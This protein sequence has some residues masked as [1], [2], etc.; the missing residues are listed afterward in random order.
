MNNL[1]D[2]LGFIPV[3]EGLVS[4]ESIEKDI[5]KIIIDYSQ[6][7]PVICY[8]KLT[9][10]GE[11]VWVRV[12][13]SDSPHSNAKMSDLDYQL[14]QRDWNIGGRIYTNLES[15]SNGDNSTANSEGGDKREKLFLSKKYNNLEY[16]P[17]IDSLCENNSGILISDHDYYEDN[18]SSQSR[19]EFCSLYEELIN[20]KMKE[21]IYEDNQSSGGIIDLSTRHYYDL[22][23]LRDVEKGTST[24]DLISLGGSSYTNIINLNDIIE[25]DHNEKYVNCNCNLILGV[26]YTVRGNTFTKECS[27]SPYKVDNGELKRSDDL[28]IRLSDYITIDYHNYCIRVFP[29]TSEVTECIISY[30]YISYDGLF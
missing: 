19:L 6:N 14:H 21:L 18:L 12:D 16:I 29:E 24:I 4:K 10:D 9:G 20:V 3:T 15:E 26:E 23:S 5:G 28:I 8:S 2:K 27:F 11:K 7:K 25:L 17:T 13:G 30:C 22:V 1:T